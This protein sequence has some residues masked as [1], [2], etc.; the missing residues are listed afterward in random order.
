MRNLFLVVALILFNQ[1]LLAQSKKEKTH[2]LDKYHGGQTMREHVSIQGNDTIIENVYFE[3][4][5]LNFRYLLVDGQRNG[6]SLVYLENGD[7]VFEEHY[8][9]GK[10]DGRLFCFYPDGSI[11]RIEYFKLGNHID[12]ST[13]YNKSGMITSKVIYN[14]PCELGNS[15]CD[16]TVMEFKNGDPVYSY[17]VVK[18]KKSESHTVLNQNLYNELIAAENITSKIEEGKALYKAN[19]SMCHRVDKPM[20]GPAL[21]QAIQNKDNMQLYE[22]IVNS[23]SHPSSKLSKEECEAL[24][25]FL[26]MGE[27]P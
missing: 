20:I 27:K 22:I 7:L 11:Q 9:N 25:E 8:S 15:E 14:T 10:L 2:V 6:K 26:K 12:T 4:G 16:K 17:E 23:G 19:C 24:M 3:N 5:Q 18:G 1:V 21:N 13:F